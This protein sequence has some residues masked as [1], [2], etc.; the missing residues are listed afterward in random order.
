MDAQSEQTQKQQ[1]LEATNQMFQTVWKRVMKGTELCPIVLQEE[2]SAKEPFKGVMPQGEP[3]CALPAL[4]DEERAHLHCKDDFPPRSAVPFLGSGSAQ[5]QEL[6]QEMIRRERQSAHFYRA[7]GR[8]VG[9]SASRVFSGMVADIE[10]STKR[11]CAVC[12]LISGVQFMPEPTK[13]LS[14]PSYLGALRERFIEEQQNAAQYVAAAA[15][16]QDPWLYQLFANLAE[17]KMRH[18]KKL[19]LLVE[20]HG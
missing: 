10:K 3:P 7:L 18:A 15:E 20:Q 13:Q 1:E 4:L 12:F 2:G 16:S 17:E 5:M 9:G 11:L 6:L 19:C 8:R 14:F